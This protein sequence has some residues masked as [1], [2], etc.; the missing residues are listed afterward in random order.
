MTRVDLAGEP[1]SPRERLRARLLHDPAFQVLSVDRRSWI[2]P[3]TGLLVPIAGAWQAAARD[4]LEIT[5]A[6]ER[7]DEPMSLEKLE[8]Q[9]W[10]QFVREHIRGDERLRYF[11]PE[12]GWLNP[13]TA[14]WEDGM[15]LEEGRL[16]AATVAAIAERLRKCPQAAGG[17]MLA[18]S[19]LE[20]LVK[21]PR[22]GTGRETRRLER[23]S[24]QMRARKV[25]DHLLPQPPS[26][27]GFAIAVHYAPQAVIGGDF[28][29]F[30]PLG[31][32]KHLFAVGDVSGHGTEAALLVAS[33][34]KSLRHV[35]RRGGGLVELVAALNDDIQ[36]DLKYEYFI[37]L[38]AAVIDIPTRELTCV[39]AGHHQAVLGSARRSLPNSLIGTNGPALG[40]LPGEIFASALKPET[41]RL[42]AGDSLTVFTDGLFE[43]RSAAGEEYGIGRAVA[44]CL[45]HA[46]L[47]A[48]DLVEAV[49]ADAR[50]F[51]GK[52]PDDDLTVVTIEAV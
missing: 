20:S 1:L 27:P 46:G 45:A 33:T 2:D 3:F 13:F 21:R 32:R 23:D 31:E 5:R 6:W 4:H 51:C 22:G 37:T 34:L 52:A 12:G 30:I 18:K 19:Q 40:L 7:R 43:P 47:P 25:I 38:F 49:T 28:Y 11:K 14:V 17:Q 35:A 9:R 26:L 10:S 24:G 50:S 29:D 44:S 48:P 15:A 42:E 36:D 8:R 39:L 41:V 16:T